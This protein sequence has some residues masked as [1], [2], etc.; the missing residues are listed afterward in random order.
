MIDDAVV[1]E[2]AAALD[3]HPALNAQMAAEITL[4]RAHAVLSALEA[5][6]CPSQTARWTRTPVVE[7]LLREAGMLNARRVEWFPDYQGTGNA[8]LLL[9]QRQRK[10]VW[11]LSH[12]DNI[13]FLLDPGEGN[14]YPLIPFCYLMQ[15][16]PSRPALALGYDLGQK[17]FVVRAHGAIEMC[18][19][20]AIFVA[21]D[22]E[23]LTPG[24]RVVYAN[25]LHWDRDTNQVFGH[26]DDTLAVTASLLAANVLR[27]Y[28]VEVLIGLTDEEEGPPGDANQSFGRGGRRLVRHFAAPDLAIISDVHESQ[29]MMHGPGPRDLHPGDGAVFA[30]R[31]SNGRGSVTPPHLYAFQQHLAVA[32]QERGTTLRENWGGYVSRSEDINATALTPNIAL[33]GVLCSN[34]HYAETQPAAN[35]SDVLDLARVFVAYTLLAH[36]T[37]TP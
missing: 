6:P 28:P 10:R 16:E 29:A 2:I 31:S 34:R 33:I 21:A 4:E 15:Q 20:K 11:I 27:H 22:G 5:V 32:L 13:S 18:G 14:R 3:A 1:A 12:L 30:E 36:G 19:G 23:P 26:L 24:T 17:A 37:L 35:L 8:V 9:G 25:D 7:G